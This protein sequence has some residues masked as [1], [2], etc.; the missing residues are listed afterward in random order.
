MGDYDTMQML[1]QT[2]NSTVI[3]RNAAIACTFVCSNKYSFKNYLNVY[4]KDKDN[5]TKAN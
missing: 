3:N 5:S 4:N 1:W 2:K